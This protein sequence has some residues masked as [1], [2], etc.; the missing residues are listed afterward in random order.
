MKLENYTMKVELLN[1][2]KGSLFS[3]MVNN[4]SKITKEKLKSKE[5]A[6]RVKGRGVNSNVESH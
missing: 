4:V 2:N 1:E 5:S 6:K 3:L